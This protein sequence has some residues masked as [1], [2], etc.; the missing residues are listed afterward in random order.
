[1]DNSALAS[2]I[3]HMFFFDLSGDPTDVV[4]RSQGASCQ[5]Q[6]AGSFRFTNIIMQSRPIYHCFRL[7]LISRYRHRCAPSACS[8]LHIVGTRAKAPDSLRRPT[9]SALFFSHQQRCL[10]SMWVSETTGSLHFLSFLTSMCYCA[11]RHRHSIQC[12][13]LPIHSLRCLKSIQSKFGDRCS[14]TAH[15]MDALITSSRTSLRIQVQIM[16]SEQ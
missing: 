14:P 16:K 2:V 12:S 11:V 1:M 13:T 4:P 9:T 8:R 6:T 7:A 15:F 5:C 10:S 3:V